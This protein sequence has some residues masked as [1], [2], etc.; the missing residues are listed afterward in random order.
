MSNSILFHG[1]GARNYRHLRVEFRG[2]A[3]YFHMAKKPAK[4]RC[5]E[6]GSRDV[7]RA[8]RTV[9]QWKTVP[10]GRKPVFLVGH[11]H[12]LRCRSCGVQRLEA[13][14]VADA[15]V[16]YTRALARYVVEL[17][18]KMTLLDIARHLRMHWGMV[19][20]IVTAHLKQQLKRRSLRQVERVGI[21]EVSYRKGHRYLTNVVD[22]DTGQVIWCAE[23]RGAAAVRPDFSS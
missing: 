11:L 14:E 7:V 23:G 21:D 6:C 8:G 1:F 10:I 22:L 9:R 2:G 20:A 16:S 15:R 19:R 12:D 3:I 17:M 13:L 18:G 5:V 4:Q